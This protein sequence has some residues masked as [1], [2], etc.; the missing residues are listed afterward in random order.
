MVEKWRTDIDNSKH[1]R[2]I[3]RNFFKLFSL[4]E[5]NKNKK[6]QHSTEAKRPQDV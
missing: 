6:K 5:C 3:K 4:I 1:S 2:K